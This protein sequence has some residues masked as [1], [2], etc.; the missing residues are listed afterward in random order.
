MRL[1]LNEN[2]VEVGKLWTPADD[3]YIWYDPS[4]EGTV[5]LQ[6]GVV[7]LQDKGS[8]GFN[9]I[10]SNSTQQPTYSRYTNGLYRLSFNSADSQFLKTDITNWTLPDYELFIA[11]KCGTPGPYRSA[12]SLAGSD[13]TFQIDGGAGGSSEWW[14]RMDTSKF[15]GPHFSTE[16]N[17]SK[18]VIFAYTADTTNQLLSGYVGHDESFTVSNFTGFDTANTT[19]RV[20][21]DRSE[22][23][24]AGSELFEMFVVPLGNR[25]EAVTYLKKKWGI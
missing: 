19:L 22:S 1:E 11:F 6:T 8:A 25:F 12:L 18:A 14:G 23:I 13:S 9:L 2:R 21:A 16:N 24:F 20:S 7:V 15:G 3:S 5:T 17:T 10:Q 4:D